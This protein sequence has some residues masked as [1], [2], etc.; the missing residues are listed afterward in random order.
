[1][2]NS[3]ASVPY[4]GGTG[5]V[6]LADEELFDDYLDDDRYIIKVTNDTTLSGSGF[7]K[8]TVTAAP[9]NPGTYRIYI[10]KFGTMILD[11]IVKAN[12]PVPPDPEPNPDIT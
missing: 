11:I 6:L 9:I 1:M 10:D 12:V 5:Q 7:L 2:V 8:I 3:I 4:S